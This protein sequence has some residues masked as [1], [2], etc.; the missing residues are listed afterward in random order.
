MR[1]DPMRKIFGVKYGGSLE[2]LSSGRKVT[3]LHRYRR[4]FCQI[5]S[6]RF[7]F[8]F[9]FGS[10]SFVFLASLKIHE[11]HAHKCQTLLNALPIDSIFPLDN[12]PRG[13]FFL[14]NQ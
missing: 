12:D 7:F 3:V 6:S 10:V 9:F 11:I 5:N 2:I 1:G 14:S 13:A 8:F 4:S